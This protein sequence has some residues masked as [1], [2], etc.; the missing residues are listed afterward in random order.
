MKNT[1]STHT[2]GPWKYHGK[3]LVAPDEEGELFMVGSWDADPS[4]ADARLIAAAPHM[5]DL[6][7]RAIP[8]LYELDKLLNPKGCAGFDNIAANL[9]K[10][11]HDA[12]LEAGLPCSCGSCRVAI[13]KAE[14]R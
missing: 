4:D 14:G 3:E 1:K 10:E 9:A 6:L 2:P 12:L 13:A 7:A 11:A 5:A 8:R